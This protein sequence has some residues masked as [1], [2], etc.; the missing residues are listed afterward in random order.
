MQNYARPPAGVRKVGCFSTQRGSQYRSASKDTTP[1]GYIR[2]YHRHFYVHGYNVG[3]HGL[4]SK[5]NAFWITNEYPLTTEHVPA[6]RR[7][8]LFDTSPRVPSAVRWPGVIEPGMIVDETISFLDFYP[9]LLAM[10]GSKPPKDFLIRGHNFLPLL[11]GRT[12]ENWSE[13]GL[14][15]VFHASWRTSTCGCGAQKI[16]SWYGIFSTPSV[17]SSTI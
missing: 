2:E 6:R 17:M 3:H 10:A 13:G 14:R 12:T 1:V 16:G 11:D 5:G 8:N 7:P 15:G 4:L 9:T